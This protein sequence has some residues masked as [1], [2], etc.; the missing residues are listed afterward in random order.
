VSTGGPP[1]AEPKLADYTGYL[2]RLAWQRAEDRLQ[3]ALPP[4]RN[5]RDLDVLGVLAECPLSQARL[6]DLLE[7]NRTVMISVIDALEDAGLVRRE[8]DP[9]DRRRY[10]LRITGQG[11]TVLAQMREAAA[12]TDESLELPLTAAERRRLRE[13]LAAVIGDLIQALPAAV[14]ERRGFLLCYAFRRLRD[15]RERALHQAG[16]KPRC[17][18]I[19]VALDSAQPCTQEQLAS[20]IGVTSPTI[21]PA[22][23]ELHAAGL[24]LRDRNPADRREHILR[25]THNGDEYLASAMMAEE[26]AQRGLAGQLGEAATAELN[27]MLNTMLSARET[28]ARYAY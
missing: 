17:V 6:G 13:L 3:P 19:L 26:N 27:T 12:W 24:I 10:A 18:G 9:A 28:T 8:R 25:L 1:I 15:R 11:G 22:V 20:A 14:T 5:S 23:D 21:V 16:L 4:G 7:I 2:L